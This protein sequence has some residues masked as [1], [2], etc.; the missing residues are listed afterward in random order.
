MPR[1]PLLLLPTCR[2]VQAKGAGYAISRDDE[3]QLVAD[4]ALATGVVLDPV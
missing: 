3:L 4:V 1:A 2:V